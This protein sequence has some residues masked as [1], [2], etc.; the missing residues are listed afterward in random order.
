[1]SAQ[2][3]DYSSVDR[4][5]PNALPAEMAVL[6][7][8]MA[9]REQYAVAAERIGPSDFYAVANGDVFAAM[10]ALFDGGKPIDKISLAEELRRRGLLDKIGGLAALSA[11]MD[12][13]VGSV[14]YYAAIVREKAD[15]RLLIHAGNKIVTLGYNGES[16]AAAATAEAERVMA[17]AVRGEV[18]RENVF[19]SATAILAQ[20][21]LDEYTSGKKPESVLSSPWPAVDAS[22]GGFH[23]GE[24]VGFVAEAKAGK[25]GAVLTL[26]DYLATVH[27]DRGAVALFVNENGKKRTAQRQL[28]MRSGVPARRQ[29]NHDW[30][31]GDID[32]LLKAQREIGGMPLYIYGHECNSLKKMNRSL[33][34]LR[35]T[36]PI[37]AIVLDHVGKLEEV[38]SESGRSSKHE[39][40]DRAYEGLIRMAQEFD[41]PVFFVQHLNRKEGGGAPNASS[42]KNIRDGGNVEGH[43]DILIIA[44]R[45]NP[46]GTPIEAA[47]GSFTI[48]LTRDGAGGEI[49]MD[50]TGSRNLW[51]QADGRSPDWFSGQRVSAPQTGFDF[52]GL[53]DELERNSPFSQTA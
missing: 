41:C 7:A 16:D 9:D 45:P 20:E 19:D 31:P 8:I 6:G 35:K 26:S 42:Y 22:T 21:L 51:L 33:R 27:G 49:P 23:N 29:R 11:I 17:A 53:E 52:T 37:C 24:L 39:R 34:A 40:L 1:L 25:S 44:H 15:L 43:A 5:P 48:A 32:R 3:D 46:L 10:G 4:I 2:P 50:Y 14:E 12:A 18:Q 13:G 36:G 30:R 38:T 47:M 28:A